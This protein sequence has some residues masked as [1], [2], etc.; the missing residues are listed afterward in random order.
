[1]S[2]RRLLS[3]ALL[4]DTRLPCAR[5]AQEAGS[6]AASGCETTV[7]RK[8]TTR[9]RLPPFRI[10]LRSGMARSPQYS[11]PS[12]AGFEYK[13]RRGVSTPNTQDTGEDFLFE[14]KYVR[15]RA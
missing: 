8:H 3:T 15:W 2:N 12:A 10:W 1:M 4:C 11:L 13:N 7:A 9:H 5:L 14:K 6:T